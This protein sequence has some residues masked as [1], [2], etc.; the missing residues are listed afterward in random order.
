MSDFADAAAD[1]RNRR[2]ERRL[3]I[4]Q[5]PGLESDK[6]RFAF[7]TYADTQGRRAWRIL[8]CVHIWQISFLDMEETD[9]QYDRARYHRQGPLQEDG[10]RAFPSGVDPSRPRLSLGLRLR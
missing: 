4:R 5:A 3:T 7:R 1:R 6:Q 10:I 8:I 9:L 2:V